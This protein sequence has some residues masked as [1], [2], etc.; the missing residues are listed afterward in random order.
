LIGSAA[1]ASTTL[2]IVGTR[3]NGP[4][5]TLNYVFGEVT[6]SIAC[7]GVL[8]DGTLSDLIADGQ[9]L[10][11]ASPES[12]VNALNAFFTPTGTFEASGATR[13]ESPANTFDFTSAYVAL[14]VCRQ[15]AYIYNSAGAT[16]TITYSGNPAG[17]LSHVTYVGTPGTPSSGPGNP[18]TP[19]VPL[20]AGV[21]LLGG[22]L[23]SLGVARRRT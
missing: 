6:C 22:A 14:K 10:G 21:F 3:V 15:T 9:V 13:D 2:D 19:Q 17:G 23:G 20:P 8:N 12:E 7:R 11:N 16:Q 18:P 5:I 1:T 4:N